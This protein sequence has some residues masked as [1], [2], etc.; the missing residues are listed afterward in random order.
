MIEPQEKTE[1]LAFRCVFF[2]KI[3]EQIGC[4]QRGQ[5][6]ERKVYDPGKTLNQQQHGHAENAEQQAGKIHDDQSLIA[7]QRHPSLR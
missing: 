4:L 1:E 5:H 2:M 6:P 7:L 3:P